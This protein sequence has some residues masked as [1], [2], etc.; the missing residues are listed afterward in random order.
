MTN[1]FELNLLNEAK[2][3]NMVYREYE[4]VNSAYRFDIKIVDDQIELECVY[5]DFKAE[6]TP[7]IYFKKQSFDGNV[8]EFKIQTTSYGSLNST[9]IQ[10]VI[11]GYNHA[12]AVVE[13]LKNEFVK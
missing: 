11:D 10:K 1:K 7:D 9:E 13:F 12:I 5:K 3:A 6:Y 4:I 8:N 2:K